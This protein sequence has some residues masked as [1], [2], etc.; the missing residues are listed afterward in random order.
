MHFRSKRMRVLIFNI[1]ITQAPGHYDNVMFSIE[2]GT[3]SAKEVNELQNDLIL[4]G[5]ID[6]GFSSP[7]HNVKFRGNVAAPQFDEPMDIADGQQSE[8]LLESQRNVEFDEAMGSTHSNIS[9]TDEGGELDPPVSSHH[10]DMGCSDAASSM[11]EVARVDT[12]SPTEITQ[13]PTHYGNITFDTEGLG[14]AGSAMD[15]NRNDS[16]LHGC[17]DGSTS[18]PT[19]NVEFRSSVSSPPFGEPMDVVDGLQSE[20]LIE[21][22]GNVKFIETMGSTH[23]NI[24]FTD[25]GGELASDGHPPISSHHIDMGRSDAAF[26]ESMGEVARVWDNLIL[27]G[28]VDAS[29]SSSQPTHNVQCSDSI[30]VS[31]IDEDM[32][33]AY[34]LLSEMPPEHFGN[35]EFN[36]E[37]GSVRSNVRLVD[38]EDGSVAD[39]LHSEVLLE[40]FGNNVEFDD[41][42]G[43]VRSNA[44][45]FNDE[46][47]LDGH[48][49]MCIETYS[50]R[51]KDG[52]ELR[53]YLTLRECVADGS[54]RQNIEFSDYSDIAVSQVC[55]GMGAANVP[56]QAEPYGNVLFGGEVGLDFGRHPGGDLGMSGRIDHNLERSDDTFTINEEA[57]VGIQ[58]QAEVTPDIYGNIVFDSVFGSALDGTK[59]ILPY[60]L[61]DGNPTTPAQ[62][63]EF[64]DCA[65]MSSQVDEDMGAAVDM[66]YE[67][68]PELEDAFDLDTSKGDMF[69]D[70]GHPMPSGSNA[71]SG[72]GESTFAPISL[73][74]KASDMRTYNIVFDDDQPRITLQEFQEG[75]SSIHKHWKL[76]NII[77]ED[78]GNRVFRLNL[79]N[80]DTRAASNVSHQKLEGNEQAKTLDS[81]THDLPLQVDDEN[82]DDYQDEDTLSY[83]G[84]SQGNRDDDVQDGSEEED[85][86][87]EQSEMNLVFPDPSEPDVF[88]NGESQAGE[89]FDFGDV[90]VVDEVPDHIN[91][92]ERNISFGDPFVVCPN[93]FFQYLSFGLI[94]LQDAHYK[95]MATSSP[96]C[97]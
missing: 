9:F 73:I 5:H 1:E 21:R 54:P 26:S 13:A 69:V 88:F 44:T 11:D 94:C 68:P 74:Y 58:L 29:G 28:G 25:G 41:E 20:V 55:E 72:P 36:E 22:Q 61:T 33:T 19:H 3:G 60:P 75:Q 63:V 83:V 79:E 42:V 16:I 30:A 70:A 23:S 80:N 15:I 38:D 39:G 91:R 85:L 59:L 17:V 47:A 40:P 4:Y 27:N 56:P 90:S 46:R 12:Q 62:N 65:V 48:L 7:R 97:F 6:G 71:V 53:D 34:G 76:G 35:V 92:P 77:F 50:V 8:V 14:E 10:I 96:V 84:D 66:Q 37:M 31:Q 86:N 82:E 89:S 2:R 81:P 67:K 51:E 64:I 24:S 43:S 95:D 45:V 52:G 87:L 78:L 49:D 93:S 32:G 18:S 57:D